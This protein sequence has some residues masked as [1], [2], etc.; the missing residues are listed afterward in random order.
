MSTENTSEEIPNDFKVLAISHSADT[1]KINIIKNATTELYFAYFIQL[2]IYYGLLIIFTYVFFPKLLKSTSIILKTIF[3]LFLYVYPLVIFPIQ[4]VVYY[5]L[6]QT[7]HSFYTNI[8]L[9]KTW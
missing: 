9:S 2:I 6:E 5:L 3:L 4:S 1:S 7:F 8:Y